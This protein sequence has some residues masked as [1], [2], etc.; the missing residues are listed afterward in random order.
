M[1]GHST[2]SEFNKRNRQMNVDSRG[3]IQHCHCLVISAFHFCNIIDSQ[4]GLCIVE[5]MLVQPVVAVCVQ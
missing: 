2:A 1:C 5:C 3:S 4:L